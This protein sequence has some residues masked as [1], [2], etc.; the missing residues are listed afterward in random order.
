[1]LTAIVC[2]SCFRVIGQ[3]LWAQNYGYPVVAMYAWVPDGL[4]KV[5]MTSVAKETMTYLLKQADGKVSYW[6]K[7]FQGN[8]RFPPKEATLV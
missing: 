1:M 7:I 5:E 6:D 3:I 4:Q 8:L 2:L